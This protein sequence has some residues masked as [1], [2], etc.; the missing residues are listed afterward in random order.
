MDTFQ[1][2]HSASKPNTGPLVI[3]WPALV[4]LCL[5]FQPVCHRPDSWAWFI[6][7]SFLVVLAVKYY[8]SSIILPQAGCTRID[9]ALEQVNLCGRGITGVHFSVFIQSSAKRKIKS[10]WGGVNSERELIARHCL[11]VLPMKQGACWE[12]MQ[13]NDCFPACDLSCV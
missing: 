10:V 2:L 5:T 4:T 8:K 12:K 6:W 13:R 3:K 7:K 11:S 9:A 1:R